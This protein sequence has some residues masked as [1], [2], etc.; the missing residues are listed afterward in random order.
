MASTIT[1]EMLDTFDE[2]LDE[3]TEALFHDV[4]T[5]NNWTSADPDVQVHLRETLDSFIALTERVLRP[6]FDQAVWN[7][8]AAP[9]VKSIRQKGEYENKPGRKPP[10][11]AEVLARAKR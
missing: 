2:Y 8:E 10:T 7:G 6:K 3:M 4:H 1:N 11:A 9:E 5:T